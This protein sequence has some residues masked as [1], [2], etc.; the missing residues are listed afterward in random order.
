MNHFAL[1]PSFVCYFY[2]TYH[3][4][5]PVNCKYLVYTWSA[6]AERNGLELFGVHMLCALSMYSRAISER[7]LNHWKEVSRS[8]L[9]CFLFRSWMNHS[10]QTLVISNQIR[11]RNR[12]GGSKSIKFHMTREKMII[13]QFLWW[14]S[15]LYHNITY[16]NIPTGWGET[17]GDGRI[18][19]QPQCLEPCQD[20][21][22]G[23]KWV[24]WLMDVLRKRWENSSYKDVHQRSYWN[25]MWVTAHRSNLPEHTYR[26]AGWMIRPLVHGWDFFFAILSSSIF[27]RAGRY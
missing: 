9:A 25:S 18:T 5:W 17:S 4:H 7:K 20:C 27:D 14:V 1:L 22:D 6:G 24:R 3:W 16:P 15:D 10:I 2:G 26:S 21:L 13:T 8:E 19:H 12:G 23:T 11:H